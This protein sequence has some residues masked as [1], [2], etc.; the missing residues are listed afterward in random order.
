MPLTESEKI[1]NP[2]RIRR[3][4][5]QLSRC[6]TPLTA[7]ISR[8]N[9]K[10]STCIV[11]VEHNHVLIDELMPVTGNLLLPNERNLQVTGK[12]DGIDISFITSLDRVSEKGDMLSYIFD[13]PEILEYRQRRMAFRIQI[14]ISKKLRVN[15][16]DGHNST[17]EGKL[18]NLSLGGAC[19]IFKSDK[20]F[21]L[22]VNPVECAIELPKNQ[23]LYCTIKHCHSKINSRG[24]HQVIGTRFTDLTPAQSR[25]VSQSINEMEREYIVKRLVD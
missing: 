10:F 16:D 20:H 12:L 8:H 18:H 9:E 5:K 19:M 1:K 7:R 15:I 25:L 11:G 2:A 14:P 24:I 21:E 17:I 23:W 4:L 3:L 13:M 22:S 6:Y